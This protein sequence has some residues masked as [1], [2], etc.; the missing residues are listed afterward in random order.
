M[1]QLIFLNFNEIE[2]LGDYPSLEST[3]VETVKRYGGK[4]ISENEFMV[5]EE[6][7]SEIA[8]DLDGCGSWVIDPC[9]PGYCQSFLNDF[10]NY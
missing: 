6:K 3:A 10:L 5:P 1:L 9:E 2:F 7:L 8:L 4:R